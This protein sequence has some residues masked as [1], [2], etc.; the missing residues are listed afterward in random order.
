[1]PRSRETWH[2]PSPHTH[3]PVDG[4]INYSYPIPIRPPCNE[5]FFC[6]LQV[7]ALCLSS[8][9]NLCIHERVRQIRRRNLIHIDYSLLPGPL[10]LRYKIVTAAGWFSWFWSMDEVEIGF[11]SNAA[12]FSVSFGWHLPGALRASTPKL[13]IPMF[14]VRILSCTL[15]HL[16]LDEKSGSLKRPDQHNRFVLKWSTITMDCTGLTP[17]IFIRDIPMLLDV[18]LDQP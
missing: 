6:F 15:V 18:I 13:P 5:R 3:T 1:M 9:R 10:I 14:P 16:V 2:R 4:A 8:R 17:D 11:I 7:L 12:F